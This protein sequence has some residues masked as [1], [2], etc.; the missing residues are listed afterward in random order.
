VH[1]CS[2]CLHHRVL[3][4]VFNQFAQRVEAF[5]AANIVL[6]VLL[7]ERIDLVSSQ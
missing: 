6:L 2:C 3:L 7:F 4:V 1:Y 5:T